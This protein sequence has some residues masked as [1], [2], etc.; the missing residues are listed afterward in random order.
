MMNLIKI[1]SSAVIRLNRLV[2][3]SFIIPVE[4]VLQQLNELENECKEYQPFY[5]VKA[6]FLVRV[7]D[8][9]QAQVYY[10][11]AIELSGNV[12]QKEFLKSKLLKLSSD[13]DSLSV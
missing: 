11:K 6:T 2:A 9:L 3:L 7:N 10:T 8:V 4:N 5:A 13:S 12:K 1:N